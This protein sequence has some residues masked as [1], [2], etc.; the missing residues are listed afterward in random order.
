MPHVP[1]IGRLSFTEYFAVA[2]GFTFVAFEALIHTITLLLPKVVINWFYRRSRALFYDVGGQVKEKTEEKRASDRVLNAKDFGELC[3]IY[4]YTHEEHVVLTKDGYLLGLHRLPSK[5]GEKKSNPGTSTGKPVVYLH[6]GLLMNSEVWVCLTDRERALPFVLVEQGYDV[7]FGNNRGNKYSKKSIHHGPNSAKFWDYSID[8][9]A[10]HD[11]P[12]SIEYILDVTRSPKL[13][14]IGFSQGTAQAFAALS[15]HPQLNLKVNVF[16]A[17]APAMSPAG[18][19]APIVDGL[20]KAS[21]TLLF[22]FFGRKSILSSATMWQSIIYPPIF[23]QVIDKSLIWLFN[24]H[25]KNIST[26]QKIAAYAH[27]YSFASVKSVVHWFQIMRNAA[28][29]MY[30]DDVMPPVT[31]TSVSSYRPARF[32]TRNIVTPIVLLYGDCD[33]LVDIDTMLAQLPEHTMAKR[34]HTYEHLDILWGK[35]VDRDVIP[36]VIDALKKHQEDKA[37][38]ADGADSMGNGHVI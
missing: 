33:S 29:Q 7:W 23:A 21:P 20:M 34:L 10:W 24:W 30:D 27:L 8:D 28:F 4:G 36:E 6:H 12:D 2:L 9:F 38:K 25:S 15:I 18:L 31:R 3:A 5:Q 35:N 32:P 16:I 22:L 17:L 11:I 1:L 14:Y 37:V 19:A 13:S 26:N